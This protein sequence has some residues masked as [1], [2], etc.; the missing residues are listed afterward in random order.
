MRS[1]S[2]RV[3]NTLLT[4]GLLAAPAVAG[5]SCPHD[6]GG[7]V[8]IDCESLANWTVE[9]HDDC[10]SLSLELVPGVEGN[11]I[12]MNWD[13]D[14]MMGDWVQMK[15]TFAPPADLSAA[16]V[17]AFSL[18]GGGPKEIANTVAVMFADADGVFF[19][20]DMHGEENGIH[21]IDRWMRDVVIPRET[22]YHF[23]THGPP[24][25]EIDWSRIDRFFVVVKRPS[26]NP[27]PECDGGTGGGSGQ[28]AFDHLAYDT[29]ADWPRQTSFESIVPD[30]AAATLA[31]S[32]LLSVRDLTTGLFV[33]WK[34]E[35]IE[36][37]PP[38]AWLYDQALVLIALTREGT[39]EGGTAV[40]T[41]AQAA[42]QLVDFLLTEQQL[43]GHW[44]RSWNP[45]TGE[46]LADDE[47]VGDQAWCVLALV[48]YAN[49]TGDP[50]AEAAAQAGAAWLAARI[51]EDGKLDAST[52][53]TVDGWWAMTA[54]GRLDDAAAIRAYL[55]TQVWDAD[56]RYWWRGFQDPVIAI[57]TATWLSEF[58]RHPSVNRTDRALAALSFVGRALA[59][60]SENGLVCGLDAMGPVQVWNEGTAQYVSAGGEEAQTYLDHL[61][62]QQ[63]LDGAMPGSTADALNDTF[64]WWT[65]W[66]GLAP[67]AWLYFSLTGTPFPQVPIVA[68][69]F[70]DGFE[71]GDLSAW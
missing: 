28:L 33:S 71:S 32:Y 40:D 12:Q 7:T 30:P 11:G 54:T 45:R 25:E 49:K 57:D 65:T 67:T 29:A 46:V 61:L 22:F 16:D 48:E 20:F 42:D 31:I 1:R 37:P 36:Q 70:A 24:D 26:P 13:L 19:G 9:T 35:E 18:R 56:L 3:F 15:H 21:Q 44:A 10:T 66:S 60:T 34:E 14:L 5:P 38:K 62:A 53:G 50:D 51:D 59:T 8:L 63:R 43:D 27:S 17:I 2:H 64:G 6:F 4:V 41:E 58:A 47:W 23:F 69:I 52:E 68:E 55:L 39:W